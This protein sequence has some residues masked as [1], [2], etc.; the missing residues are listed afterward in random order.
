MH[1]RFKID[2]YIGINNNW[3]IGLGLMHNLWTL[4]HNYVCD[5][6]KSRNP[7]WDDERLFQ[8]ARLIIS[9]TMARIHTLEW[10][11]AILNN[12]LMKL[13][14][15]S[16]WYG[17]TLLEFVNGNKTLEAFLAQKYPFIANGI[18]GAIGKFKCG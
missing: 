5:E 6:L 18:P 4:E 1:V 13:G 7:A 2:V 8:T 11:L 12:D 17:A 10:T 14:L 16:N 9:A 3:W 15:K